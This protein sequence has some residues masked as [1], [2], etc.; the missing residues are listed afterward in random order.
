M[1][2]APR[3]AFSGSEPCD[4]GAVIG[5]RERAA[6]HR[7]RRAEPAVTQLI[8][9][10]RVP[11]SSL[12]RR[13]VR[14]CTSLRRLRATTAFGDEGE[15][16]GQRL[17]ARRGD[18]RAH[19]AWRLELIPSIEAQAENRCT[20]SDRAALAAAVR[21]LGERRVHMSAAATHL[22][23]V[24]RERQDRDAASTHASDQPHHA[25]C[26]VHRNPFRIHRSY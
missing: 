24:G 22:R 15:T 6:L 12:D 11:T 13:D 3:E 8:P 10:T 7:A 19:R 21:S 23:D 25:Q 4:R 2:Q 16:R 17:R 9:G 18:A 5:P 26:S 14:T 1:L 20:R